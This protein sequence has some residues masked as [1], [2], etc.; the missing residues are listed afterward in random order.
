MLGKLRNQFLNF[1]GKYI[2]EINW[3]NCLGIIWYLLIKT[4]A[5]NSFFN[6]LHLVNPYKKWGKIRS[7]YKRT[8]KNKIY[9]DQVKTW[10][11]TAVYP[12]VDFVSR[13]I[14]YDWHVYPQCMIIIASQKCH[15]Y[16]FIWLQASKASK[17]L[18][19]N[20]GRP[21]IG[22]STQTTPTSSSKLIFNSKER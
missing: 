14:W 21:S 2:C 22:T 4:T 5:C 18:P 7:E 20:R 16:V 11:H 6:A 3:N 1:I 13:L 10:V 15:L 9:F 12:F 19:E 8:V 17:C